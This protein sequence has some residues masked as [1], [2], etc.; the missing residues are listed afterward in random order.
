MTVGLLNDNVMDGNGLHYSVALVP[1]I[2][3][4]PVLFLIRWALKGYREKLQ[5]NSA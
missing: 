5:S 3:G 1:I 4:I 2:Y